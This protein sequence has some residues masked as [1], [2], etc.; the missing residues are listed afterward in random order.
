MAHSKVPLLDWTANNHKLLHPLARLQPPPTPPPRWL[1]AP[2]LL[3]QKELEDDDRLQTALSLVAL[4]LRAD[5]GS[6]AGV[7]T[8]AESLLVDL[9][10]QSGDKNTSLLAYNS[11]VS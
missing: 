7:R 6:S 2:V 3:R 9:E 5:G 1:T 11:S 8:A 10:E 4:L